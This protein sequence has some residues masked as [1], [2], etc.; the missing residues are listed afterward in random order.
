VTIIQL[1]L[2]FSAIKLLEEWGFVCLPSIWPYRSG[3]NHDFVEETSGPFSFALE[4]FG[5]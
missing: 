1:D 2:L 3:Q 4:F 5:V